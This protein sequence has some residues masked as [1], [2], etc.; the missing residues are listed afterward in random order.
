MEILRETCIKGRERF[1][2]PWMVWQIRFLYKKKC[3]CL[4]RER[5]LNLEKRDSDVLIG[6]R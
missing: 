6:D 2:K 4:S 3:L 1:K 5:E